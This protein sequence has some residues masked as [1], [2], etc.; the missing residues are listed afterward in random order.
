MSVAALRAFAEDVR[1][2]RFPSDDES[3]HLSAEVAEA[4]ASTARLASPITR[5]RG[6]APVAYRAGT[7]G[8]RLPRWARPPACAA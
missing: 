5:G 2:R 7:G 6:P 8:L 1:A 3:Y 4:S